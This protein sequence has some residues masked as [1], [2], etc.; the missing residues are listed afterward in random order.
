MCLHEI[1]F[2]LNITIKRKCFPVK[3]HVDK[4]KYFKCAIKKRFWPDVKEVVRS[5]EA[6]TYRL[7]LVANRLHI[8]VYSIYSTSLIRCNPGIT[9]YVVVVVVCSILHSTLYS[10]KNA[11]SQGRHTLCSII[12]SILQI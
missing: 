3:P 12:V 7:Q 11:R 6:I 4:K 5:E 8:G 2:S 9:Y 10:W 1:F